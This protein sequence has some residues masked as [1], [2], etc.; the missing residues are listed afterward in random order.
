MPLFGQG[1]QSQSPKFGTNR[2]PVFQKP[3]P[4]KRP[5]PQKSVPQKPKTLFEEKKDWRR[6]EFISR[7]AKEPLSIKGKPLSFYERK[8]MVNETF[9]AQRFSTYISDRE[10]KTRLRELR[11]GEKGRPGGFRKYLEKESGLKGKY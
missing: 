10:A 8:K 6:Q 11:R 5:I 9:P 4:P 3:S 7:L 2:P 1:Q